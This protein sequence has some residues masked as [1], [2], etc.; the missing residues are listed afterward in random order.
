MVERLVHLDYTAQIGATDK[1]IGITGVCEFNPRRWR[2]TIPSRVLID[3]KAPYGNI[4]INR[5][6]MTIT[7]QF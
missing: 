7:L 1:C 5:S 3:K 2:I 6:D 4:T